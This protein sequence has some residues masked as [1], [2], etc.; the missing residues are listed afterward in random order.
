MKTGARGSSPIS[1]RSASSRPGGGSKTR[2]SNLVLPVAQTRSGAA[3]SASAR[4]ASSSERIRKQ[5]MERSGLPT[6]PKSSL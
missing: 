2:A 3:P 6:R 5:S 4:S 1:A